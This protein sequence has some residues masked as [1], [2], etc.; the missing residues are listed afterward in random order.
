VEK[1]RRLRA[2]GTGR[3]RPVPKVTVGTMGPLRPYRKR[4]AIGEIRAAWT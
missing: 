3:H 1:V 2:M 4:Y